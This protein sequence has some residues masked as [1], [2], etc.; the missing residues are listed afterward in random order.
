MRR[1]DREV[2]NFEEVIDI[3][4]RCEVMHLA[5]VSEGKPYSVPLNFG[6]AVKDAGNSKCVELYFHGAKDGKK[7]RALC[8]N[9]NVCFSAVAS[10]QAESLSEDKSVAC[11]W[12]CFYESVIGSGQATFLETVEEKEA[13]LDALMLHNG[14]KLPEGMSKIPYKTAAF[15]HVTVVKITVDEITGK[16]HAKG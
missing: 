14:Y 13:A 8:E 10:A 16:R 4:S 7:V 5:M 11:N 3:L 1:K 12:T 2:T 15:A 9:P 6:F